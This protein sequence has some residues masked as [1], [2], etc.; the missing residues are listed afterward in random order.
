MT[1]S[2]FR[3]KGLVKSYRDFTLGPLDLEVEPGSVIALVGP[4]GSGKTT[5]MH[6]LLG[7]VLPDDGEIEIAGRS[8]RGGDVSWKEEVGFVGEVQGYYKRWTVQ[9]NFDFLRRFYPRWS[10]DRVTDLSRRFGLQ[11]GKKVNELSKGNRR[12]MALV[13]AL[14]HEPKVLLFD[15]PTSGL[16]PVVRAEVLDVLWEV[17]ED[18]DASI[19]YSTHVLSDIS[20]L[21]DELVFLRDGRILGRHDKEDLLAGWRRVTFRHG[22][23][24]PV[25]AEVYSHRV[26]GRDHQIVT[27]DYEATAQKLGELG[28]ENVH[29]NRMTVEEISVEVLRQDHVVETSRAAVG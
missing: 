6:C 29:A 4:N 28:A 18:G 9:E 15:E 2:S 16:D 1:H 8:N 27:S 10:D 21:A 22:T 26:A 23:E 25:M 20:R 12:K 14:A 11:L 17:L 7:L 5:T 13:A 3:M 19:L 24:L